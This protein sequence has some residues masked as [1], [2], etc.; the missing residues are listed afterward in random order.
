MRRF[1]SMNPVNNFESAGRSVLDRLGIAEDPLIGAD[2]VAFL[3]SLVAAGGG[4]V[5]HP[6]GTA[7]ANGRLGG[8]TRGSPIRHSTRIRCTS[9]WSSSTC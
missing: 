7:A 5:K 8:S 2:P 6:S 3:R 4:L 1:D 9:C